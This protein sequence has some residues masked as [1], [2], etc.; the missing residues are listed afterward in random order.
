MYILL[1]KGEIFFL[2]GKKEFRIVPPGALM[3]VHKKN[4]AQSV[5]LFG[6]L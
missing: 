5:H 1:V 6:W 2:N 3:S 4:S